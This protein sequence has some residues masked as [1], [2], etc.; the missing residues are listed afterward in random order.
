[1][2]MKV[3]LIP[4]LIYLWKLNPK[5]SSEELLQ[6]ERWTVPD[7]RSLLL[8]LSRVTTAEET[9]RLSGLG[10]GE[11]QAGAGGPDD[12]ADHLPKLLILMPS[13]LWA[14]VPPPL[15]FS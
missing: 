9:S 6:G 3:Q 15:L 10:E 5:W 4:N 2:Q 14:G 13:Y 12:L 8:L 7:F 1:M 11:G